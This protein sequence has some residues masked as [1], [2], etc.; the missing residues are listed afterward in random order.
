MSTSR[1]WKTLPNGKRAHKWVTREEY[2]NDGWARNGWATNILEWQQA[3]DAA[4]VKQSF[5]E[6][7]DDKDTR[8]LALYSR[9]VD[10]IKQLPTGKYVKKNIPYGQ[11]VT[12]GW[13]QNGWRLAGRLTRTSFAPTKTFRQKAIR[14]LRVQDWWKPSRS[15]DQARM[16]SPNKTEAEIS[17]LTNINN[18]PNPFHRRWARRKTGHEPPSII[19]RFIAFQRSIPSIA[20]RNIHES[21]EDRALK[22]DLYTMTH[23]PYYFWV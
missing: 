5:K 12:Q 22:H 17:Q 1:I 23:N 7:F 6:Q 3:A 11:F 21:Y 2:I 18:I 10:I 9:Y 14:N 15:K 8:T 19:N 16:L 13:E 20:K 4:T